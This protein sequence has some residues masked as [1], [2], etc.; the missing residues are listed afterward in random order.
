M[1]FEPTP[2]AVQRRHYALQGFSDHY[3]TRAKQQFLASMLLLGSQ[4][5]YLGCCMVAAQM[6]LRHLS[7]MPH[8]HHGL[9][10]LSKAP[11]VAFLPA[12]TYE[13]SAEIS[14]HSPLHHRTLCIS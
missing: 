8:N 2:S 12:L 14:P 4:D 6:L 1:G 5:N 9:P 3:K 11:S 13:M 10:L 7:C